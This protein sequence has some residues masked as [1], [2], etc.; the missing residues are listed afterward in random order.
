MRK[1][2]EPREN[3]DNEW[4]TRANGEWKE[5]ISVINGEVRVG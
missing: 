1:I 2:L 5:I 4:K 3:N